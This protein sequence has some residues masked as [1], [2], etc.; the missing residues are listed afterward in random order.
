MDGDYANFII[1]KRNSGYT[2]NIECIK[3]VGQVDG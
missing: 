1:Q 3:L 2:Y